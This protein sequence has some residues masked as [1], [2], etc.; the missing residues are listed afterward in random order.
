MY[1]KRVFWEGVTV[2]ANTRKVLDVIT[3][4]VQDGEGDLLSLAKR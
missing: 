3:K 1:S 4:A 2:T